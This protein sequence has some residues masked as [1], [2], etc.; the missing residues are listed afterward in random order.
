MEE[1]LTTKTRKEKPMSEEQMKTIHAAFDRAA[2]YYSG[3]TRIID[4]VA[5]HA[6]LSEDI[7]EE[8]IITGLEFLYNVREMEK[9]AK[10]S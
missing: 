3:E 8:L 2:V 1:A 10:R 7:R 6:Y 5:N 4:W 9:E